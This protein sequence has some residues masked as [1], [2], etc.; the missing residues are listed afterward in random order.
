M[1]S[2]D[3]DP[4]AEDESSGGAGGDEQVFH[5]FLSYQVETE[6]P[7]SRHLYDELETCRAAVSQF[8]YLP[9]YLWVLMYKAPIT[10]SCG[11]N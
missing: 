7:I 8:R 3:I 4:V 2:E 6:G 1:Y 11:C 9:V 10:R 5:A